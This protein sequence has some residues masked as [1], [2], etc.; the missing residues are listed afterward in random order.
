MI[1]FAY[2][3]T[4]FIEPVEEI[5]SDAQLERIRASARTDHTVVEVVNESTLA[6]CARLSAELQ[7]ERDEHEEQLTDDAADDARA[8]AARYST[9]GA[10]S[11]R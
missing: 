5:L 1:D 9:V 8:I 11:A 3:N 6:A 4:V 7:A 2:E 10:W